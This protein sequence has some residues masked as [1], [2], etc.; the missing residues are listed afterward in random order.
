[1]RWGR[2]LKAGP[3]ATLCSTTVPN[4]AS[5]T[6]LFVLW[7]SH[8]A[9]SLYRPSGGFAEYA[10]QDCRCLSA[11]CCTSRVTRHASH[12][13]RH[14]RTLLA[15]PR[16]SPVDA[17]ATPCAGARRLPC[18]RDRCRV[19]VVCLRLDRL[20]CAARQAE[21]HLRRHA[22]RHG[23]QRRHGQLRCALPPA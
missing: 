17:A 23:R 13:T 21:D 4:L 9:G 11:A 6:H 18:A 14:P 19:T 1:M 12:V 8:A 10:I 3:W 22:A 16:V 7:R 15:H 20:P 2:K 5:E